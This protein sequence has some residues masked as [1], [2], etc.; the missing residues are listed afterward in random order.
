MI[1][2]PT[3]GERFIGNAVDDRTYN[4]RSVVNDSSEQRFQPTH[5]AFAMGVHEGQHLTLRKLY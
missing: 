3:I 5:I 4:D 2:K 1:G